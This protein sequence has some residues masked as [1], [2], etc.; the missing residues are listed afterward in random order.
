MNK[1]FNEWYIDVN[2]DPNEGQMEKRIKCIEEYAKTATVDAVIDLVKMYFGIPVKD[3][4]KSTFAENFSKDDPTFSARF[5]EEL[6]LL[7]G[8]TLVEIAENQK[9]NGSFV[10]LLSIATAC[11]R[12]PRSTKGILQAIKEQ[13]DIDSLELRESLNNKGNT[14]HIPTTKD[15]KK[16]IDANGLDTNSTNEMLKFMQEVIKTLKDLTDKITAVKDSQKVYYEDSQILWWLTSGWSND[17]GC[18]VKGLDKTKSCLIIGNEAADLVT[19][20]PG[21]YAITGVLNRM[22]ECSKGSNNKIGIANLITKIDIQWKTKHSKT[23][24]DSH[25]LELLPI[26]AAIVRSENTTTADEWFPKYKREMYFNTDTVELSPVEYAMQM[27]LETM[28]HKCYSFLMN[29]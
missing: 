8:A 19:C 24:N 16:N 28:T 1:N 20:F 18:S 26:S 6:S 11:F 10:E 4:F 2:I 12:Q 25:L 17:L 9:S 5:T 27:Y 23:F 13:F 3:D 22:I 15:L 21:P 29:E 7:A 14:I